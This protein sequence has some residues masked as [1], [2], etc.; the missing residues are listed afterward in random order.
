MQSLKIIE[1]AMISVLLSSCGSYLEQKNPAPAPAPGSSEK[2]SADFSSVKEAVF[3]A[4]CVSCHQQYNTYQGVFRE[5]SAI[6]ATVA[7]NRM[8]KAG[9][10]L[11]EVQKE[12]LF[13]W[14]DKGA[15]ETEGAPV[16]NEPAVLIPTFKS[17]FEN[18]FAPKCLVCH[19]PQGQ[20]KFFDL[21]SRAVIYAARN[22]TFEGGAKLI[23]LDSP[24]MSYLFQIVNDDEL[25]MPPTE[26]NISRLS[27]EQVEALRRWIAL[28]LPEGS[29]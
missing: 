21:S 1:L 20:A 25:P 9:G 6:R 2:L 11:N 4:R 5:L 8:P 28:G 24:E 13:S 19:N 14:I 22:R 12:I 27:P 18:V 23:D 26:S 7:S 3:A 10:P 17:L 29:Q 15:P 16:P